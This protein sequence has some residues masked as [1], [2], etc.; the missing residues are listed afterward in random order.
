M[1]PT[2]TDF[3]RRVV[4]GVDARVGELIQVR[5]LAGRYDILTEVMLAVEEVG[6]VPMP[7]I[8]P[9]RYLE[10]L[11]M[12]AP[13][14]H[15]S[16]WDRHRDQFLGNAHRVI[17]LSGDR[18]DFANADRNSLDAWSSAEERLTAIEEEHQLPVLMAAV[19]THKRAYMLGVNLEQLD[20]H[21][22]AALTVPATTLKDEID[23]M[24]AIVQPAQQLTLRTG[25]GCEL[26]LTQG[27]RPWQ[28][29]DGF[30]DQHDRAAGAIVS[31]LP[32]GSIATS[33]L[34]PASSGT[35]FLP[36]LNGVKNVTLHITAG[37][38]SKIDS[39]SMAEL[40]KLTSWFDGHSGESRRVG[41]LSIG[42]NPALTGAIGWSQ[43]DQKVQGR[44]CIG[45]GDNAH[46]GGDNSSTLAVTVV[47][48]NTT[49]LLADGEPIVVAQV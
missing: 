30:I 46:L 20:A 1:T 6:A 22:L 11:W 34:E 16:N 10:R 23:R 15:L 48:A 44:I 35:L 14:A 24:L 8:M 40:A 41:H 5:D 26:T 31:N 27:G 37:R 28:S 49:E 4:Q 12:T 42:L 25:E 38:V 18:P 32:A 36:M 21:V 3:A 17:T 33:V 9:A 13:L 45:L 39:A 29:D 19:P 7:S 47:L 2:W 43:L